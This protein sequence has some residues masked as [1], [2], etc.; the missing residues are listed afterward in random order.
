MIDFP[1]L[2]EKE[3]CIVESITVKGTNTIR[4]ITYITRETIAEQLR[5]SS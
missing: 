4:G 5:Q 1:S 3:I 2:Y